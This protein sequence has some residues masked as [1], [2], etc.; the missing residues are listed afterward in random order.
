MRHDDTT[1]LDEQDYLS[2]C[3]DGD[4]ETVSTAQAAEGRRWGA[5]DEEAWGGWDA[6]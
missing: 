5:L 4:C 6:E 2:L 3:D 1:Y